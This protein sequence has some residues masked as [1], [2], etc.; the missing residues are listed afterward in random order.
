V[1]EPERVSHAF[2][3]ASYSGAFATGGSSWN[4]QMDDRVRLDEV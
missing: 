3:F 2:L 1:P 4:S